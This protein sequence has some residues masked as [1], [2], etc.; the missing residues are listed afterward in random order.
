MTSPF[1]C[2]ACQD[3]GHWESNCPEL[4]PPKTKA[5]YE[6]RRDKYV[7][8]YWDHRITAQQKQKLISNLNSA[9]RKATER[10]AG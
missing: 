1:G 5:E 8:W 9:W 6:D 7:Q 4:Q 2:Y 10:K 3:A